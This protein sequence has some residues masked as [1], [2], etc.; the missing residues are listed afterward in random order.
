MSRLVIACARPGLIRGGVR[1]PFLASHPADAFTPAQLRELMNE[2]ALA[3]IVGGEPLGEHHVT[4][5]E[6]EIAGD[7][8]TPAPAQAFGK[9]AKKRVR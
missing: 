7:L 8:P 6:R 2:P 1:H 5:Y 4:A 3:V 9:P